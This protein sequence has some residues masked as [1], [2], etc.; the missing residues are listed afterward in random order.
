MVET[1]TALTTRRIYVHMD[2]YWNVQDSVN[3]DEAF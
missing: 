1:K 2:R 3:T